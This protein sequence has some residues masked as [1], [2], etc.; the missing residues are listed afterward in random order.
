MTSPETHTELAARGAAGP[1]PTFGELALSRALGAV[2][3]LGGL[4]GSREHRAA[5]L[6]SVLRRLTEAL[7]A[8][9]EELRRLAA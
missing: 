9:E 1:F 3:L 7:I 8:V 4:R 5:I 6:S 2:R